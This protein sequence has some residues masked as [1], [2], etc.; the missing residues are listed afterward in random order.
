MSP[1][2]RREAVQ[3]AQTTLDVSERRAC[4]VIGQ[5]RS[6]QRYAAKKRDDERP[7]VC[8]LPAGLRNHD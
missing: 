3:E 1:A 2:R 7:L 4:Q 6:T 5:P 8:V